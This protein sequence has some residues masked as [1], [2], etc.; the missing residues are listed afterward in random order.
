MLLQRVNMADKHNLT[1]FDPKYLPAFVSLNIRWIEKFFEVE[2]TDRQQLNN[3]HAN[4][5]D[6]GGEIFFLLEGDH[7]VGTCAM[8]PHHGSYELAKMAVHPDSQGKGYGDI[9]MQAAI[10]WARE[11]DLE[12]IVLL[13]N[14]ILEPAICLYKKHGFQTTMLGPHPDYK[15]CNIEM[16]LKL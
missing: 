2:E 10:D 14:T 16:R 1:T 11:K 12:E 3:P 5:L 8:V 4:I 9:L 6:P 13:S 7:C 15:R